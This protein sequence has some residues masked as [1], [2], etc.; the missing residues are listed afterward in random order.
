MTQK[1]LV[2]YKCYNEERAISGAINSGSNVAVFYKHT[3]ARS[4]EEAEVRK[5]IKRDKEKGDQLITAWV[6]EWANLSAQWKIAVGDSLLGATS[7]GTDI[8]RRLRNTPKEENTGAERLTKQETR[9]LVVAINDKRQRNGMSSTTTTTATPPKETT[10]NP[11]TVNP[12]W[13]PYAAPIPA[14]LAETVK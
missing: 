8:L 12:P 2:E 3:F 10:P 13:I 1:Y 9:S 7:P 14:K 6:I 5:A 4:P 11:Y